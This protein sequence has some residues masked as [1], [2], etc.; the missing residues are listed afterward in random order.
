MNYQLNF[1]IPQGPTGPVAGLSVY[2]G[3]YNNTSSTL[4]LGLGTQTQ[5]PLPLSL[6]SQNTIYTTTN[7]ITVQQGG[8]YEINYFANLSVAIGTTV[9]LAVRANGT[10]IPSTVTSKVLSVSTSSIYSGSTIVQ[11]QANTNIDMAISAL[12]AVGITLNTGTNA[13]ITVKKIS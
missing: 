10:N 6:P 11:L 5:I 4:S 8:I 1:T 12:V 9:T 2:G 7:S 3:K 13:T